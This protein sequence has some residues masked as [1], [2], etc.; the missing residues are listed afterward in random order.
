IQVGDFCRAGEFQGVV[1]DIGLRSTRLRTLDRTVVSIPNGQLATMSLENFTLRDRIRFRH[2][3]VLRYETAADQLRYVL[4]E[5]R[6]LLYEHSKVD[7]Q[8]ARVRFVAFGHSSLD[9]E[10]LAYVLATD[11]AVFLGIQEDLLLRIMDIIEASGTS[12][13]FPSQTH[14]VVGYSGL[15][16][17]RSQ[18][19]RKKVQTWRE[20]SD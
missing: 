18:E 3:I 6:R 19:A 17:D 8:D 11:Y 16:R 14:Y 9:V 2:V 15:N 1:E 7:S 5:I 4:A 10:I 13:A 20:T 12:V